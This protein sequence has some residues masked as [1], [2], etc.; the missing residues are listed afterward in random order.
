MALLVLH[1]S[2]EGCDRLLYVDCK[3]GDQTVYCAK[4]ENWTLVKL[5]PI[6]GEYD[7]NG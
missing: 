7:D 3:P 1:C 5:N 4:C 6:D 2:G